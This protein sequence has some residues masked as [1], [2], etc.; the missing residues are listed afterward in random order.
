MF[1][2]MGAVLRKT[3]SNCDDAN[4]NNVF[5]ILLKWLLELI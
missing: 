3:W 5:V 4:A 1:V 2:L